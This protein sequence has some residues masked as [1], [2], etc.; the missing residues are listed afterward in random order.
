LETLNGQ[1]RFLA[2]TGTL[3]RERL[4]D[5]LDLEL[6]SR[7]EEDLAFRDSVVTSVRRTVRGRVTEDLATRSLDRLGASDEKVGSTR[8]LIDRVEARL[9]MEYQD[10]AF[11]ARASTRT[12][13]SLIAERDGLIA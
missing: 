2:S 7:P 3:P 1:L 5:E 6:D 8:S 4:T 11:E 12:T 10:A 9:R 13:I